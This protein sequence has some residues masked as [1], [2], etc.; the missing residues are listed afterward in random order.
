MSTAVIA[1]IERRAL[2]EE[3]ADGLR[4]LIVEGELKPG[5]K[6]SE[7]SLCEMFGV[8]RTPLRE[9]LKI[10]AI[11]GLVQL[12]P[13][14]GASVTELKLSDLEE[15]FPVIAAMEGLAGELACRS[16]SDTEIEELRSLQAEMEI[17][18]ADE[19][20]PDYFRVN[21]QI[22]QLII[23]AADNASLAQ[24][25]RTMSARVKRAR[26]IANVSKQRWGEAVKEHRA[27]LNALEKRNEDLA[28]K[29]M[30]QHIANK[31]AAL[32]ENWGRR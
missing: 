10:L 15:L 24:M 3:L 9:A 32:R 5:E 22:H 16:I 17:Y 11:E 26:F 6:I 28:G 20:L 14:R 1:P 23:D 19:N 2:H 27:I 4:D 13:N 31:F 8:S 29:L 21:Q 30:K 7:K 25:H 12:T 18:H